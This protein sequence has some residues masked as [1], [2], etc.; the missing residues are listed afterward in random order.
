MLLVISQFD[1]LLSLVHRLPSW[2]THLNL[3]WC[4]P[5]YKL[6]NDASLTSAFIPFSRRS[7]P[8]N[9]HFKGH[10]T[11]M[12]THLALSTLPH[13]ISQLV[14]DTLLNDDES[15]ISSDWNLPR[16]CRGGST[17][18]YSPRF[19][20]LHFLKRQQ[21]KKASCCLTIHSLHFFTT[22]TIIISYLPLVYT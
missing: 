18:H 4:R 22:P 6:T 7:T 11:T 1:S 10:L 13:L 20:K 19:K 9:P 16:C 12:L 21:D 5:N 15:P 8:R 17:K 14:D 3:L 2:E